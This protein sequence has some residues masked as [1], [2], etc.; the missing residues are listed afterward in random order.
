MIASSN[1]S[2][3]RSAIRLG[4]ALLSSFG[5]LATIGFAWQASAQPNPIL[6]WKRSS[7]E[8]S[9]P[10]VDS[11]P[12]EM[13][14]DLAYVVTAWNGSSVIES[15]IQRRAPT[16]DSCAPIRG[17]IRFCVRSSRSN[18]T[19]QIQL[20]YTADGHVQAVR[21][22]VSDEFIYAAP[23]DT[24]SGR[25]AVFCYLLGVAYG[26]TPQDVD[27]TNSDITD[28]S[29]Q[30][31]CLDA[32]LTPEGNENPTP[33]DFAA[34]ALLYEHSHTNFGLRDFSQPSQ[35]SSGEELLVPDDLST[36]PGKAIGFDRNGRETTFVRN[37]PGGMSVVTTVLRRN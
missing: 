14:G 33:V 17:A 13:A 5:V 11:L 31:S 6:H 19:A 9:P 25:R 36:N 22:V 26:A 20:F 4:T 35:K 1:I 32:S 24:S 3:P 28:A 37:L 21:S 34:I 15:A 29:G 18:I 16:G 27:L 10:V 2:R 30:Q 12:A 8:I 23:F 7:A